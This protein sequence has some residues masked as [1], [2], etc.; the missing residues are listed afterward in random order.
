MRRLFFALLTPGLRGAPEKAQ[1]STARVQGQCLCRVQ[2]SALAG[3][4]GAQ[5]AVCGRTASAIEYTQPGQ[6]FPHPLG[7]LLVGT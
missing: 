6:F 3:L 4:G 7:C 5:H 2:G 1:L